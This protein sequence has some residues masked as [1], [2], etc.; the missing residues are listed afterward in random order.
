MTPLP[1]RVI[2]TTTETSPALTASPFPGN[3]NNHS[4][5]NNM[6]QGPLEIP[7][8][9]DGSTTSSSGTS[10]ATSICSSGTSISDVS[11]DGTMPSIHPQQSQV[12]TGDSASTRKDGMDNT[13]ENDVDGCA[14][15]ST[16]ANASG[17][18]RK[19]PFMGHNTK[20]NKA[21]DKIPSMYSK[22]FFYRKLGVTANR[23]S[24]TAAKASSGS[25][26]PI[27]KSSPIVAE[28]RKTPDG[29]PTM[30]Q[31]DDFFGR[32]SPK[33][34]RP[35][36][37]ATVAEGSHC[38]VQSDRSNSIVSTVD[39]SPLSYLCLADSS[40][41]ESHYY[42]IRRDRCVQDRPEAYLSS[43]DSSG[44]PMMAAFLHV[45]PQP[46]RRSSHS[47]QQRMRSLTR[48]SSCIL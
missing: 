16:A 28:K 25:K 34:R 17:A 38:N 33:A 30:F 43:G 20:L 14:T 26:V 48:S 3:G 44:D 35:R 6:V 46:K 47:I 7:S 5:D 37:R 31:N 4:K 23:T 32:K 12:V 41:K 22:E 36:R 2:R 15:K 11:G 24:G 8:D 39:S 21:P 45:N 18:I 29:I 42:S 27:T 1:P 9:D 13:K 40:N 10:S 19:Q